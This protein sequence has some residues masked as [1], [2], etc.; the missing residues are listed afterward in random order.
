MIETV[1]KHFRDLSPAV[2]FCSLR[3]VSRQNEVIE[4]RQDILQ[5]VTFDDDVGAMMAAAVIIT[6][7]LIFLFLSMQRRFIF[8]VGPLHFGV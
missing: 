4:V 3:L 5:P 8:R 7:P 2:D 1:E 6:V